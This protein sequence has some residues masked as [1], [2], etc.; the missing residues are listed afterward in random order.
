[1]R[2]EDAKNYTREAIA[3]EYADVF[4]AIRSAASNGHTELVLKRTND[5]A[6][7]FEHKLVKGLVCL[8]YGISLSEGCLTIIWR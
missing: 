3:L 1:M 7:T 6:Y 2:V 4:D 8:G 5:N